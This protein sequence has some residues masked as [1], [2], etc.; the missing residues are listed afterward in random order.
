MAGL[1]IK[2]DMTFNS[3]AQPVALFVGDLAEFREGVKLGRK[4][5]ATKTPKDP[6]IVIANTYFK[7]NEASLALPIAVDTVK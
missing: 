5:Y 3:S 2:I 6:D 1:D 4:I 7:S